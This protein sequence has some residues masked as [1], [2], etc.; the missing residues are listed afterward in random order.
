MPEELAGYSVA[1]LRRRKRRKNP[2]PIGSPLDVCRL[3]RPLVRDAKQEHFYCLY[4]DSRN[5]VMDVTLVSLGSLD[6]AIVQPR[7]VFKGAVA[8]SAAALIACHNH[9]SGD[10][11]PSPDDKELTRRLVKCGDILG[12]PLMDHVIVGDRFCTSYRNE[13]GKM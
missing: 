4:L 7:E 1:T 10:P 6:A 3:I 13:W 5:A 2:R 11:D 12:I 8:H 9:P